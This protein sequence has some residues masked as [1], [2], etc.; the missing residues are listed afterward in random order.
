MSSHHTKLLRRILLLLLVLLV[1]T[2]AGEN[3]MTE[4]SMEGEAAI[5]DSTMED[6]PYKSS[7]FI[8]HSL[9]MCPSGAAGEAYSSIIG[10][11]SSKLGT[12]RFLPHITL[13]A[14]MMTGAKD[15]VAR[16]RELAKQLA[17]YTFEFEEISQ[18]DAYF[19]CVY[20]KMKR[21][22]EVVDA[23]NLAREIFP[24]RRSD[25][26][27]TPHLSLIYGDFDLEEKETK[28]IPELRAL[29]QEKIAET[30]SFRVDSIEVWSTQGDVKDWYLVET[31]PLQGEDDS[32]L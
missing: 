4:K 5:A 18:R 32:E 3:A 8:G 2:V 1:H 23:N 12:F 21:S 20:A 9:W 10:E 17:P 6:D 7:S 29:M 24:E 14:A 13:V 19:Q 27:Y 11:T 25:S 31:I 26:Y 15:V 16:T 28:L 22:K 30:K